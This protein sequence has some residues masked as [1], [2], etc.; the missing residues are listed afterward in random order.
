MDFSLAR[1][2][3]F[4]SLY[5]VNLEVTLFSCVSLKF[6]ISINDVPPNNKKKSN[7]FRS[8]LFYAFFPFPSPS[9]TLHRFRTNRFFNEKKRVYLWSFFGHF[10]LFYMI[11]YYYMRGF[12][13][14]LK[15]IKVLNT[16]YK[17]NN[18]QKLNPRD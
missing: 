17:P 16:N 9:C 4:F 2:T 6:L 1:W 18:H 8:P 7:S 12:Y 13:L 5:W 3:V 11:L 10:C 14:K 15:A